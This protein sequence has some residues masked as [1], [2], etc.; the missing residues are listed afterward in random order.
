LYNTL[1]Q[2]GSTDE[3]KGKLIQM[4]MQSL[5]QQFKLQSTLKGGSIASV[6]CAF[7]LINNDRTPEYREGSLKT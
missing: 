2:L 7:S 5:H 1:H 6:W 3:I 4:E